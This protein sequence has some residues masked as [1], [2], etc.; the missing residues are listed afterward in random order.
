VQRTVN[1]AI[2]IL[3]SLSLL[4]A[5]APAVPTAA[6]TKP[7]A[8]AAATAAPA[9]AVATAPVAPATKPAAAAPTAAPVAKVKRGGELK[10]SYIINP[11]S[12]DPHI[13]PGNGAKFPQEQIYDMLVRSFFNE[14]TGKLEIAPDLALSWEP[15][16]KQITM[17]LRQGVKFTDGS[18]FNAQVAKWNLDRAINNK[19]SAVKQYVSTI[20]SVDVVDDYTIK[21]NLKTPSASTIPM[22]SLAPWIGSQAAEAKLGEEAYGANPVG[23]GPFRLKEWVRDMHVLME[24]NPNYWQNGVDGKPLPYLD[25]VRYRYIADQSIAYVELRSGTVDAV[26]LE[27]KDVP[28]AKASPAINYWQMDWAGY[29]YRVLG[30]THKPPFDNTTLRHALCYATD[31]ESLA[32]ALAPGLGFPVPYFWSPTDIGYN[33]KLPKFQYDLT[34]SQQLVKDAGYPNGIDITLDIFARALDQRLAEALQSMWNKAGFRV[35]IVPKE[36]VAAVAAAHA[37]EINAMFGMTGYGQIDPD[38]YSDFLLPGGTTNHDDLDDPDIN[39]WMEVGRS[40]YEQKVR[41]E[42][43]EN[44][45]KVINE[46]MLRCTTF[47]TPQN[48]TMQKY[49]KGWKTSADIERSV[50]KEVWLDK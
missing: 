43:Y 10:V 3:V 19:K 42:A 11:Y 49:V 40:T 24:A 47:V 22:L 16:G 21:L 4:L 18:V 12:I 1:L 7:S 23:S 25:S 41:Q 29:Q 13:N 32:K 30:Y 5:C 38:Q 14:S 45:Q 8:A 37:G 44:V 35:T 17:K 6:P 26:R 34:K 15:S 46:K 36:K 28:A 2:T 27:P 48:I 50:V 9:P 20:E 39:K 31:R 33:D